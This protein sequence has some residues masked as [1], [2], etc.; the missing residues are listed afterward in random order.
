[1]S[2]L[3]L[4]TS[5]VPGTKVNTQLSTSETTLYTCAAGKGGKLTVKLTNTSGSGVATSVSQ[6]KTGGTASSANRIY[7]DTLGAGK[8]AYVDV[9]VDEGDFLSGLA[10]TGAVVDVVVD[11][12]EFSSA[13]VG[14]A[15]GLQIDAIGTGGR[16]TSSGTVTTSITVGT[17][18][19][20]YL[21]VGFMTSHDDWVNWVDYNT[22]TVVSNVDGALTRLVS[23]DTGP[24]GQRTG[25]VHL[26]GRA[27][28]TNGAHTITCTLTDSVVGTPNQLTANS[29]AY[30]GVSG[31]SG[32]ISQN[33]GSSSAL[34]LSVSSATT[35]RAVAAVAVQDGMIPTDFNRTL[36][37]F[38]GASISNTHADYLLFADAPGAAT[39]A[40]TTS[41]SGTH[42]E[43][44]INLVAA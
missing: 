16:T 4:A 42:A 8:S 7:A 9:W 21:I 31:T 18:A 26:F 35:D 24:S 12:I 13:V 22:L 38:N 14:G 5:A 40:F 2:D 36:R 34:N 17:G 43:V 29:L 33:F 11:G 25:S 39:V 20:R 1:M 15:T 19:N 6:V 44:G 3:K 28:P 37:Y 23:A 30:T 41:N 27:N 32:A 10:A